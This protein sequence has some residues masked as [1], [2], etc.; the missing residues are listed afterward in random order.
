MHGDGDGLYLRVHRRL[1]VGATETISK[2][3]VF[4]FRRGDK[5]TEMG[6]GGYGQG[7]APVSLSLAREKAEAIRQQLAR[8]ED[9]TAERRSR[10]PTTFGECV[11]NLLLVKASE[12]RNAKHLHQWEMT[13]TEYAKPLHDIP[14]AT[15]SVDDV[16]SCLTP[17]WAAR[18]ETADRLRSRI[19]AVVDY[20]RARGL[21]EAG[22]PAQWKGLLERLLPARKALQRGHH[23]ALDYHSVP[24]MMA[25]LRASSGVSARATEFLCLTATRSSEVREAVWAE[26][27]LEKAV[28]TIPAERMKMD[29]EHRVPLTARAVELLT[30]QKQRATGDLVFGGDRIGRPIS[31]TAMTK[32]LRRASPDKAATLHGLRS[33]FRDWAGDETSHP[34]EVAEQALAHIVQGVEAA[35]RRKDAL[36]KRRSLMDD[37]ARYCASQLPPKSE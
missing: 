21:R 11:T 10:S 27:D 26:V 29:K 8:G 19:A 20:A 37:W 4:V 30:A 28:W 17:H 14:I 2:N 36:A 6:L 34:R 12:L 5:R 24:A 32:S 3:W 1:G 23:A 13:L 22:N 31:D 18:Q 35:Y 9:P 25:G 16:V 7:T 15:L 33:S